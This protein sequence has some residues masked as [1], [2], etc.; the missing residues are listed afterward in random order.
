MKNII[1][2]FTLCAGISSVFAA[3]QTPVEAPAMTVTE[4]RE[5]A[6]NAANADPLIN[7]PSSIEI[8]VK[9]AA[10]T[11]KP[12][13]HSVDLILSKST[14][15]T[16]N[17]YGSQALVWAYEQARDIVHKA[18]VFTAQATKQE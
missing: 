5:P 18:A 10:T 7:L 16:L 12:E 6:T 4:S 11:K 3:K 13:P 2:L 17:N 15:A 14:L 9:F 1:L 8:S